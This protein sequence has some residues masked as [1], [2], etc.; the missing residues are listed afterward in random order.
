M[1]TPQDRNRAISLSL[2]TT[3]PTREGTMRFPLPSRLHTPC[4]QV[5]DIYQLL[6]TF[7]TQSSPVSTQFPPTVYPA[8]E[9]VLITM[10]PLL[11]VH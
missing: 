10:T 9:G 8:G 11:R 1:K 3:T 5:A 4:K 6:Y 2:T 7:P